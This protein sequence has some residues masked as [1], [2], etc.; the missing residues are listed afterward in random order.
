MEGSSHLWPIARDLDELRA[1]FPGYHITEDRTFRPSRWSAVARELAPGLHA[2]I[3]PDLG[4]FVALLPA[5]TGT[6]AGG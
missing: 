3:T 4:E 5:A 1:R 6:E 2:V